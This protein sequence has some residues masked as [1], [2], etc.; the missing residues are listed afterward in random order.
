MFVLVTMT[1]DDLFS[2]LAKTTVSDHSNVITAANSQLCILV[3]S[4]GTQP[5]VSLQLHMFYLL[6]NSQFFQIALQS[7]QSK[8]RLAGPKFR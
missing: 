1:S 8:L 6:W 7:L 4:Y 5:E 3:E 2:S